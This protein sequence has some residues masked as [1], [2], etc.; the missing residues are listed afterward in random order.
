M[1]L[2]KRFYGAIVTIVSVIVVVVV[3]VGVVAVIIAGLSVIVETSSNDEWDRTCHWYKCRIPHEMECRGT[4][5]D[6]RDIC[7]DTIPH[8]HVVNAL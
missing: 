8:A 5:N 1:N 3:V 2:L 4:S 6:M 7:L